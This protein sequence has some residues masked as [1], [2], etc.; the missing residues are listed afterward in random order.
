M[1]TLRLLGVVLFTVLLSVCFTACGDDEGNDGSVDK[2]SINKRLVKVTTQE[3]SS[4]FSDE[5]TY[6]SN[7]RVVKVVNKKNGNPFILTTSKPITIS[8]STISS[9]SPVEVGT[10]VTQPKNIVYY[11]SLDGKVVTPYLSDAF[12]VDI[13][14]N[15]YMV[16]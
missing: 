4:T 5:F 7:G 3:G 11:T 16:N 2:P 12:G 13:V 1:K 14:S 6:D 10:E 9:M 15:D 8:R